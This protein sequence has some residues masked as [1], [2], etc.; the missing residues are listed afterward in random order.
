MGNGCAFMGTIPYSSSFTDKIFQYFCRSN[1]SHKQFTMFKYFYFFLLTI[2]L[3]TTSCS[4]DDEIEEL[5]L[6]VGNW[7]RTWQDDDLGLNLQ[8]TLVFSKDEFQGTIKIIEEQAL[9]SYLSYE[10]DVASVD[11]TLEI[12]IRK[13]GLAENGTSFSYFE[14]HHDLFESVIQENLNRKSSSVGTF[15]LDQDEL[16][17]RLDM[18]GDG[19]VS[20]DEGLFVYT[21]VENE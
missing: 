2:F 19:M 1:K 8:E 14:S 3:F 6:F 21:K 12:Q 20:G 13:I 18:N 5:P 4:K 9:S 16:T 11:N 17:L 15:F 7:E 10:G